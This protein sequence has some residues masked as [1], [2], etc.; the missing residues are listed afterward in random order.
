[1]FSVTLRWQ[2]GDEN[3]Y[4]YFAASHIKP[5]E[6]LPR[7]IFLLPAEKDCCSLFEIV[8]AGTR[9]ELLLKV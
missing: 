7:Q 8:P 6:V 4:I 9:S 5:G 3:N 1:M 2:E